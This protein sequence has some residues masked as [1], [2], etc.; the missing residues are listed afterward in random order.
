MNFRQ[1]TDEQIG[2]ILLGLRTVY[3][4][5]SE[6]TRQKLITDCTEALAARGKRLADDPRTEA[7]DLQRVVA[8]MAQEEDGL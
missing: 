4:H 3:V 5:D 8:T 7:R 6:A 2:L 1:M